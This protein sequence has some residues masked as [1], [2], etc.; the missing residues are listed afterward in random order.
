MISDQRNVNRTARGR[1]AFAYRFPLWRLLFFPFTWKIVVKEP[2]NPQV[3][4]E[5]SQWRTRIMLI[6]LFLPLYGAIIIIGLDLLPRMV[7]EWLGVKYTAN[8]IWSLS[9]AVAA[10]VVAIV[11][12]NWPVLYLGSLARSKLIEAW[13]ATFVVKSAIICSLVLITLPLIIGY[14]FF[15]YA[16]LASK[17]GSGEGYLMALAAVLSSGLG[18]V[19]YWIGYFWGRWR[20]RHTES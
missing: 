11:F 3:L 13:P 7:K 5:A 15:A 20:E 9:S 14:T 10:I 18:T 19:G 8:E 17:L 12:V 2:T 6:A 16:S 1:D 4:K